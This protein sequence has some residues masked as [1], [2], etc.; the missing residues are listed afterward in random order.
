MKFNIFITILIIVLTLDLLRPIFFRLKARK[1]NAK[2]LIK[3]ISESTL[4]P[5]VKYSAVSTL[6]NT[7]YAEYIEDCL[8]TI[9]A[10]YNSKQIQEC[11]YL[12]IALGATQSWDVA[13]STKSVI[14]YYCKV[15]FKEILT[16][17]EMTYDNSTQNFILYATFHKKFSPEDV[18]VLIDKTRLG[19]KGENV[20]AIELMDITPVSLEPLYKLIHGNSS[21]TT[22]KYFQFLEELGKRTLSEIKL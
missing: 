11:C 17:V 8:R 7:K 15:K 9:H 4:E 6:S 5:S 16:T 22:L 13:Q 10:N 3:F 14:F 2:N 12:Q 18:S 19:E 21:E 1:I 20:V